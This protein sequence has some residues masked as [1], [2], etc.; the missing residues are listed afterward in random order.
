M[1]VLEIYKRNVFM[2][3][4]KRP[5][6]DR[7][8]CAHIYDVSALEVDSYQAEERINTRLSWLVA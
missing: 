5:A 4:C 3:V 6:R 1:E 7:R 8:I 2:D